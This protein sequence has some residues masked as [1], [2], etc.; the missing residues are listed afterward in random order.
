MYNHMKQAGHFIEEETE[1]ATCLKNRASHGHSGARA[2]PE[3]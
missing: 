3:S 1:A 2:Q